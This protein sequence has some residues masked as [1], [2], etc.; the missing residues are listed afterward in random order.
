[1]KNKNILVIG[2]G[3]SGI[4]CIKGLAVLGAKI[5]VYD[6]SKEK[7]A[8]IPYEL[9][10]IEVEYFF[11][12]DEIEKVNM[13]KLD[14]AIKSPGIKYEVPI[15]QKLL[16]RNIR[17]I[18]DIEAAYKVTEASIISITGTNGK[19]TT[20][21]L[22]GEMVKEG[23]RNC[24]VTGNIGSGMFYDGLSSGKG[25]VL[26]A[27]VSSFQLAGT[28]EYKPFISVITNIT[29]DHLDYHGTLDSYIEAKFKNVVNQDENDYAVLNYEDET[30][31][32]FADKI[33]AKKIFFSS[34]RILDEGIY[35]KDGKMMFKYDGSDEFIINAEDIFIPGKHNLENAMAA[36][37]ASLA[38]GIKSEIIAHVLKEFKG[39]EH[40]LEYCGEY[41]GVKFYN[42]SKGTN[43][44]ASIKAVQGIEKPIILIAG[45]YDKKSPYDDF[46]KA[47]DGK[48]K[49]M[50]LLGQ[51]AHDIDACA[52]K[53]GFTNIYHVKNMDEAVKKC[54]MLSENGDNVV[55]SPAC[56]SWGMYP[57]Y[58]VRGRDF[59]ER[60]NY[61][62][63]NSKKIREENR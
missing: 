37:G 40:R 18:S 2:L 9:K 35:L 26:V 32:R 13:E 62:G 4:A 33:K 24:R 63:G 12:E 59:K 61:Y 30:I 22:I 50:V 7:A 15:V 10:E 43:P 54:F 8:E 25:D 1:M 44:D 34:E 3:V 42:D 48:V 53:H 49:A 23:G 52:R 56:A 16:K 5:S 21:T 41:D 45:G 19:T 17:I 58:E 60:V 55:L 20:T 39:V 31:R 36:T 47:F 27:E 6:E 11:G 51:T 28:Y 38:L 14:F 29:P 57:N 46:I